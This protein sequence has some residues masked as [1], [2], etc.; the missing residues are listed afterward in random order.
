MYRARRNASTFRTLLTKNFPN[1]NVGTTN[2]QNPIEPRDRT[3]A[4]QETWIKTQNRTSGQD[5]RGGRSRATG[6]SGRFTT[7]LNLW[8]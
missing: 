8:R 2:E 7:G 6:P 5:G 3:D 1:S 4:F